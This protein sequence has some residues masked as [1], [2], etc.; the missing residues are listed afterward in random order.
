MEERGNKTIICSVFFLD[1]VEYSKKSVSGQISLKER[2]NAFL[3][4]A[5]REV[6]INDRII[7]D[8]GDGAAISFLGDVEDA[9]RA[10]LS[11]R[12]SLLSEEGLIDP[13]LLVRMGVNL[14]PVRLVKDINGQP[15][16]VGDGINVA[17]RVMGFSEPGQILV[18]RSYYDAA[19]RI[20][21]E[22]AGM[23]HYEGSRTD[24]HV[25][26]HE[27]YAIGYPG[28]LAAAQGVASGAAPTEKQEGKLSGMLKAMRIK[29]RD[30]LGGL[31]VQCSKLAANL[32][33]K[34]KQASPVQKALYLGLAA[35]PVLLLLLVFKL[36]N[37]P[38]LPPRDLPQGDDLTVSVQ[39]AEKQADA[40]NTAKP[41]VPSHESKSSSQLKPEKKKEKK[42]VHELQA[43]NKTKAQAAEG[44]PTASATGLVLLNV[45]PWCE[46]YLD[47]KMIDV[48]PP[49]TKLQVPLG[50][51]VVELKNANF[52]VYKQLVNIK[53]GESLSISYKFAN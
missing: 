13:L 34:L 17:Q 40:S 11:M 36:A 21:Q 5:I 18:S 10:A 51:H 4:T 35:I 26:E 32:S 23:F 20:S 49:L 43:V 12:S 1:I 25:R 37:K 29:S 3:S 45:K 41:K 6:P 28:D 27:V 30:N 33:A 46:V 42:S 19:S 15:N 53:A 14:G 52:P 9:L 39:G 44:A 48:S 2:F 50:P 24:K 47:G 8:T 38:E 16:I 22:Y 7:L 31:R